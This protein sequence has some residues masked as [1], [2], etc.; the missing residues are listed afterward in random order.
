MAAGSIG[1]GLLVLAIK[2]LAYRITGS[3]AL[4]SDALES[5]VNVLTA[6]AALIAIQ[7]GRHPPD[8]H[9][10]F[11]HHKAE[12]FSAVL[13]GTLIIIAALLICRQA[14]F[15]LIDPHPL[16]APVLGLTVNAIATAINA[17][18]AWVLIDRGKAWKSPALDGDGRHLFSDVVT[19]I[20]VIA[21]LLLATWTGW[22]ILDPLIAGVVALNILRIGYNLATE[23]MSH[24]M[25][26]AAPP[27]VEANIRRAIKESADGALQAHDLRTRTAGPAL[28]IEFHLV[29]PGGMTVEAAH[30]ICDR[31]EAAIKAKITGADVV[32][33]VEPEFKAK[34][35]DAVEI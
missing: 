16:T 1:I 15:A 33:H 23:S 17:A 25:D 8:R 35:K 5:I 29:V 28:F 14:Y 4:F 13:E 21:G 30:E 24:L 2:Y 10:Q 9:H 32:I 20:G 34:H 6:I 11:G 26:Q 18:W 3:V 27:Q 22:A 12:Y 7:V 31:L 19:S